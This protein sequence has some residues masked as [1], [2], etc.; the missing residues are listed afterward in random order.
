L[1]FIRVQ[2]N[3]VMMMM[4][5]KKITM[6]MM[7]MMMVMMISRIKLHSELKREAGLIK[8]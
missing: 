8:A 2:F 1:S 6:M 4:M 7:K 3:I 5:N